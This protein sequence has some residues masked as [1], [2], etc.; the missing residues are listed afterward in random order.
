MSVKY[1]ILALLYD[2]PMHGY[3]VRRQLA[4][5]LGPEWDVKPA[6]IAAT[7]VRMS[8]SDAPLV[9]FDFEPGDEAPERKVYRLTEAGLAELAAWYTQPEV[10]EYR[11]GDAFYLKLLFSLRGGPMQP[12]QVLMT[13]RR[14]LYQ[15]LHQATELRRKT[16]PRHELPLILLLDSAIMHLEA[17]LRWIEMLDA[18]LPDLKQ[19]KPKPP[20]A[21]PRGRPR[22]GAEDRVTR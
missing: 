7:L 22:R 8:D 12:E 5:S 21:R 9:D 11:L 1:T 20:P 17:D 3:E 16:D 4:A 15:E 18:R 2:Q 6:Q 14:E 13:Q 19:H 10:R